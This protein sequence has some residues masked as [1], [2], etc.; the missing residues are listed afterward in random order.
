MLK[1]SI[2]SI[3]LFLLIIM[4]VTSLILIN[5]F[6]QLIISVSI[7]S[8]TF[9]RLLKLFKRTY[10]IYLAQK[11]TSNW[12]KDLNPNELVIINDAVKLIKTATKSTKI[13]PFIMHRLSFIYENAFC[14][15][16]PKLDKPHIFFPFRMYLLRG[17]SFAFK[18]ILHEIIHSQTYKI[19][20][21]FKTG[22][23]EG[24]TELLTIWLIKK[25][26]NKYTI[27]N[28]TYLLKIPIGTKTYLYSQKNFIAYI[29]EVLMVT[30]IIHNSKVNMEDIFI[31]YLNENI[32]FFKSFVPE[33]YFKRL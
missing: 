24:L 19:S 8:Y 1:L 26:S 9:Y 33:K 17:E 25:Y 30:E 11:R 23:N 3:I 15:H 16:G 27:Q 10:V 29:D 2:I 20:P 5:N 13:K 21:F 14:M 4:F 7:I 12:K 32:D 28:S 31:N 6:F 18:V 22:F